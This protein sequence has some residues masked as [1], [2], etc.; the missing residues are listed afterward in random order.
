MYDQV[1]KMAVLLLPVHPLLDKGLH[2]THMPDLAVHL[3]PHQLVTVLIFRSEYLLCDH[4]SKQ[5]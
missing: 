1:P 3:P 5:Q 4:L 2:P